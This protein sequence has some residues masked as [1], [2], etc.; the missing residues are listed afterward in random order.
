MKVYLS[1]Y[2]YHWI[3]PY[4]VLEKVFFWREIDY[5]EPI[6]EKWSDRL[7]PISKAIQK[8]LDF[9]HPKIDYVKVD[10][11]DTWNMDSSLAFIILPMLKQLK[12]TK[13]GAPN[14]S[15]DDVP[16]YL[17]STSAKPKDNEWD[18]D[19]NWHLRWDWVLQEMI[20]AFEQK[21]IDDADGKFFDHSDVLKTDSFDEQINK[22]KVDRE[23]LDAWQARKAN[24]FR[25]FG[26]YYENL[27]D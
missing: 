23:G 5:N 27:W 20:W 15:D 11:W 7:L 26:K 24:G 19:G 4:T 17:K 2:R 8:I 1:K 21:V 6:I 9:I 12:G 16:N 18:T 10:K 25:L 3:S 14:V 13:H 22:I